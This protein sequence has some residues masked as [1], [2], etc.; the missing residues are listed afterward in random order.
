M[1]VQN[2]IGNSNRIDEIYDIYKNTI[3]DVIANIEVYEHDLPKDVMAEIAEIFQIIASYENATVS[4]KDILWN[5]INDTC[6]TVKESLYKHA[7][8]LFIRKIQEYD[9]I[10]R[11]Y[12]Y[13]GVMLGDDKF[14]V[15]ARNKKHDICNSLKQELNNCYKGKIIENIRY[16]RW[17]K[18][19][20]YL[21]GYMSILLPGFNIQKKEVYIPTDDL[22]NINLKE[23]YND[24][25]QL[26]RM[27][28]IICPEV[29]KNGTKISFKG[30]VFKAVLSWVLPIILGVIAVLKWNDIDVIA[31]IVQIVA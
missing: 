7:I 14:T 3:S 23:I 1:A 25:K 21:K 4:N 31:I 24:S 6:S 11:Q 5:G 20:E 16:L 12:N 26:L 19:F 15:L 17:N 8:F 27:Y 10:F 28:Q 9:K 22:E 30:K 29:I 18:K 2:T 13:K